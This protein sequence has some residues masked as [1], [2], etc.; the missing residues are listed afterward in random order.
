MK[1]YQDDFFPIFNNSLTHVLIFLIASKS[2]CLFFVGG[3]NPKQN[4]PKPWGLDQLPHFLDH[5]MLSKHK[6]SHNTHQ[7]FNVGSTGNMKIAGHFTMNLWT[8]E[9]PL[10]KYKNEAPQ[11]FLFQISRKQFHNLS[12]SSFTSQ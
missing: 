2:I 7:N 4:I 3:K 1:Q 10:L 6:T 8:V 9:K 11:E 5:H 12:F